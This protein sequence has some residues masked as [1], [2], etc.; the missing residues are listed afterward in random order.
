MLFS[1]CFVVFNLVIVSEI[2]FQLFE[3]PILDLYKDLDV[4]SFQKFA[5]LG[6]LK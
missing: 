3:R 1:F 6:N 2:V 5:C 4:S